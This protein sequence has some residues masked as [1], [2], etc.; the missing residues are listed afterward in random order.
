MATKSHKARNQP[1]EP[2]QEALPCPQKTTET[3]QRPKVSKASWCVCVLG[4]VGVGVCHPGAPKVAED[5]EIRLETAR[6]NERW[7]NGKASASWLL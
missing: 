5:V 3:Q 6:Q 1:N 2:T 7:L 4:G